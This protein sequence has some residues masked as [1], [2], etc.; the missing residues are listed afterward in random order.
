MGH[1]RERKEVK[2]RMFEMTKCWESANRGSACI[3]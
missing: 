3:A 2:R 1:G